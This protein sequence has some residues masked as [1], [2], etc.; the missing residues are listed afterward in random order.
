[1]RFLWK[2]SRFS[3][4]RPPPSVFTSRRD[5][6]AAP[7]SALATGFLERGC[8]PARTTYGPSTARHRS[9][10][11]RADRAIRPPDESTTRIKGVLNPEAAQ[12]PKIRSRDDAR[13]TRR[14]L[15]C[16]RSIARC[17]CRIT[18]I[19]R[20]RSPASP[21]P[22]PSGS[23]MAASEHFPDGRRTGWRTVGEGGSVI[24]KLKASLRTYGDPFVVFTVKPYRQA[25]FE[26]EGTVTIDP[27]HVNG[28]GDE[29]RYP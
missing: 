1:M 23:G 10:R 22:R 19:S 3:R 17:R 8:R 15:R 11:T 6:E 13:T 24:T 28:G 2:R 4:T 5:D 14:R 26:V 12:G 20:G 16:S 29:M 25:W 7:P 18:K 21:R 27:D 9:G